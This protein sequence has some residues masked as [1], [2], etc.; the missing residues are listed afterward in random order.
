MVSSLEHFVSP[1]GRVVIAGDAAHGIPPSAGQGGSISLEDA[2]TLAVAISS[3]NAHARQGTAATLSRSL[4]AGWE[5]QRKSRVARVV[6][7]TERGSMMRK[8]TRSEAAQAERERGLREEGG[9]AEDDLYWLY[10]FG[11]ERVEGASE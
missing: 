2:E 10:G 8:A 3:M 11:C 4:L 9:R 5:E 1:L 7:R 6:E